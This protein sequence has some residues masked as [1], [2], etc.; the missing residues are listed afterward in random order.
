MKKMLTIV[1]LIVMIMMVGIT[2]VNAATSSSLA[3]DVYTLGAKYG[4]TSGDRVKMERYLTDYPV[5][6]ADANAILSKAQ[7]AD[8]IMKAAGV[9]DFK[10]L[11]SAQQNQLKTLANEA[12]SI[13]GVT[14]EFKSGSL[15]V[16]KDGKLIESISSSNGKLAYTGNN[17]N[18]ALVISSIAVIALAATVV[19]RKKLVNAQ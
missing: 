6:D 19:I 4:M 18:I 7:Q 8:D 1:T 5:S 9:T 3:N 15:E 2:V 10:K 16:Y 12:A 14:L 11:T 13:A 17:I